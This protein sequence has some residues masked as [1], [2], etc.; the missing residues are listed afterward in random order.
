MTRLIRLLALLFALIIAPSAVLAQ[1]AEPRDTTTKAAAQAAPAAPADTVIVSL[2]TCTP[3]NEVYQY[4]GHTALRVRETRNGMT[5]DWVFNYGS[6]SFNK[7]HFMWRFVLGETDYEL[8]VVPYALFYESYAREGRGIVEQRLNLTVPEAARLEDALAEN[9]QP[10]NAV[11]RY[12]FFADNCV[13][14][15][16]R[17]IE[18]AV[19]G[20]VEW[21]AGDADKSLR[22]IVHQYSA[23]SPW[24]LFGQDMLLGC[25]ADSTAGVQTQM[26]APLYAQRYAAQAQIR[27]AQGTVRPLV[28]Q[29]LTLLP[30]APGLQEKP[31]PVTPA[32]AFGLVLA[33][34][35]AVSVWEHK[36]K[37]HHWVFDALL[38][39]LQGLAGC[40]VAFLFCFSTHPT[41]DSNWLVVVFNPLPLLYVPW[42]M[43]RALL[44]QS[45]PLMWVN[46]VLVDV[47]LLVGA[48][49]VQTFAP[50]MYLILATLLLR[51]LHCIVRN[52]LQRA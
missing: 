24:N 50:E 39:A 31:L 7:P 22:D 20:R 32:W 17:I 46:V 44:Q 37:V 43:K 45:Q 34:A 19:D 6:F 36:K 25:A 35:I 2:L 48:L 27:D 42:F 3:G 14:R 18:R 5:S 4:Y 40:V 51:S 10:E 38:L 49:S 30:E 33:L 13:T 1:G 23:V 11:Y 9:L 26:F 47:A 16:L 28:A 41:V 52:K 8:S 15:A 21:P 12:N 29:T